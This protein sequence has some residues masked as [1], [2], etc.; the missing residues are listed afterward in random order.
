MRTAHVYDW[1]VTMGGG[2]KTL[3]VIEDIY[4]APIHT[5]VHDSKQLK[6]TKF[7]GKTIHT[8]FIQKLPFANRLYRNYLP[9][10]PLA[11]E[12]FDLSDY[13]LIISTS[14]AANT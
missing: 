12:Q 8:S 14:H 3:S 9:F 11:I 5:L 10:F 13:D 2:E 6:G 1:L 4:P 7:E